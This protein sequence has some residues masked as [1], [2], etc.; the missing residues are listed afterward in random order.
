MTESSPILESAAKEAILED[1]RLLC[2]KC[3]Y[4]AVLQVDPR[5]RLRKTAGSFLLNLLLLEILVFMATPV[6]PNGLSRFIP[7]IQLLAPSQ[8]PGTPLL[9]AFQFLTVIIFSGLVFLQVRAL[10]WKYDCKNC[11]HRWNSPVN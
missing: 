10:R 8:F 1:G 4:P 7:F 9:R 6:S 3:T 5:K 11:G 2:P